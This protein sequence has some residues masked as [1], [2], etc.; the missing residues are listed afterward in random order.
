MSRLSIRIG[1]IR[2]RIVNIRTLYERYRVPSACEKDGRG[3]RA[4]P[5]Y[6]S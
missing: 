4:K 2:L 3:Y 1:T 5:V 6:A